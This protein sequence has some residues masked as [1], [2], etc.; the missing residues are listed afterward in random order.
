MGKRGLSANNAQFLSVDLIGEKNQV[1]NRNIEN[2]KWKTSYGFCLAFS[3]RGHLSV[4][5][6]DLDSFIVLNRKK[7][8]DSI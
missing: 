8:S 6:W 1:I 7:F 5:C 4:F 3:I 2:A